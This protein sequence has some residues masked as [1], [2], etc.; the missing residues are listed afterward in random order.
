MTRGIFA[1]ARKPCT[2]STNAP[3]STRPRVATMSRSAKE[4]LAMPGRSCAAFAFNGSM[5]R[6]TI[7]MLAGQTSSHL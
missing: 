6:L 3:G 2:R 4:C 1:S 7:G 5:M